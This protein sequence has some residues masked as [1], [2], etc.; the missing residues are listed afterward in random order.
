MASDNAVSQNDMTL[1]PYYQSLDGVW[2]FQWVGV[3]TS[4]KQE[5]LEK[6]FDDAAWTNI[7]VPSSWD[8]ITTSRGT[9]P[10]IAIPAIPSPMMRRPIA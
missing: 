8:C 9:S 6:D 5:W 4:A 1:S 2:K 10:S 7:D 3:P